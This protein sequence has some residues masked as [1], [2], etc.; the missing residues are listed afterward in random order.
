MP[1][2]EPQKPFTNN[3]RKRHEEK[4]RNA[5]CRMRNFQGW[6]VMS[7]L[8][9]QSPMPFGKFKDVRTQG[10]DKI[11]DPQSAIRNS[12]PEAESCAR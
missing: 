5:E 12:D 9:D 4:L 11:C 7:K 3:P 1:S 10:L 8:T 6:C 2:T